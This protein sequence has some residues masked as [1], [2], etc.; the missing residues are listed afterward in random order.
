MP[1]T[2]FVKPKQGETVYHPHCPI[3]GTRAIAPEGEAVPAPID[4]WYLRQI[5][6]GNLTVL[7]KPPVGITNRA[8]VA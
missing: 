7:D 2:T 3:Q 8:P 1:E 4:R 5:A 6:E